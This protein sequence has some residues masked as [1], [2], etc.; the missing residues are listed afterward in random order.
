MHRLF[1]TYN[2]IILNSSC[3]FHKSFVHS[4]D[5]FLPSGFS[6][7]FFKFALYELTFII[8]YSIILHLT[9]YYL[10]KGGFYSL[11]SMFPSPPRSTKSSSLMMRRR[12]FIKESANCIS[13]QT[14]YREPRAVAKF[15]AAAANSVSAFCCRLTRKSIIT[16]IS[17]ASPRTSCTFSSP[18]NALSIC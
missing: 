5:S 10:Q 1:C 7:H 11:W 12:S 4:L 2:D 18:A 13:R 15:T 8:N 16:R 9:L 17:L 3:L 14:S 6:F